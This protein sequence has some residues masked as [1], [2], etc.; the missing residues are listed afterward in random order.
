MKARFGRE[1]LLLCAPIALF[2]AGIFG[3]S[4]WQKRERTP[5]IAI[6][7]QL[8]KPQPFRDLGNAFG[9][10]ETLRFEW[11]AD[12]KG[13]PK[14]NYRFGWNERIVAISPLHKRTVVWSLSAP[15]PAWTTD[16]VSGSYSFGGAQV[17]ANSASAL[18][19]CVHTRR[20]EFDI[21]TLPLDTKRLE[22]RGEMVAIPFD[23]G[24]IYQTPMTPAALQKWRQIPGA[25][26]W[27]GTL[28]LSFDSSALNP[29]LIRSGKASEPMANAKNEI[30]V[31]I[32]SRKGNRRAAHRLVAFD[33]RTR[34]VLW[35]DKD[36]H[37]AYCPSIGLGGYPSR[38]G[39]IWNFE[40]GNIPAAWGEIAFEC[41]TVF[42]IHRRAKT[43]SEYKTQITPEELAQFE[44]QTSGFRVS[45]RHVLRP[46]P[47]RASK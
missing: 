12:L 11:S 33:G 36:R 21:T 37:N 3:W 45:R 32:L 26:S 8:Q 22:W 16:A 7:V 27:K 42:D 39:E 9:P 31:E 15:P 46:M 14:S 40:I 18:N 4:A 5:R 13:G 1:M 35:S 41:D 28:P 30:E 2:A 20:F 10:D 47:K 44:R 6:S 38:D 23:S 24:E 29:V 34:R 25:A 17:E 19:R 43:V